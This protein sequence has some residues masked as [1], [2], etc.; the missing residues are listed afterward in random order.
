MSFCPVPEATPTK[1]VTNEGQTVATV[2][3]HPAAT[4]PMIQPSHCVAGYSDG[5]IRIF[6]LGK[7]EMIMKMQPHSASITAISF[8]ADGK[9]SGKFKRQLMKITFSR[10]NGRWKANTQVGQSQ[11]TSHKPII[12]QLYCNKVDA[13]GNKWSLEGMLCAYKM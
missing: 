10:C 8:S 5:T 12:S 13:L 1:S 7:V 6:D 9:N 2:H 11:Q 4:E 3:P